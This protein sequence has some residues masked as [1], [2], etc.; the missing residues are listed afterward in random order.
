MMNK[1][2]VILQLEL[3]LL[4]GFE[5]DNNAALINKDGVILL[6]ELNLQTHQ[7]PGPGAQQ[8]GLVVC[9]HDTLF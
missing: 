8:V 4:L 1:V 5:D 7:V 2:G 6:P 3:D 9:H